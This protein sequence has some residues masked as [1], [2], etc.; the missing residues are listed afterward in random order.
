MVQVVLPYEDLSLRFV[1]GQTD[2]SRDAIAR[3]KDI[4][5]VLTLEDNLT[6]SFVDDAET[7]LRAVVCH[8]CIIHQSVG[9]CYHGLASG[10][11]DDS[12]GL[13]EGNVAA[14][15]ALWL[16]DGEIV[17]LGIASVSAVLVEGE[18]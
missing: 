3:N 13:S 15:V 18:E 10:K 4:S 6:L 1:C 14:T 5:S 7:G 11:V 9:Q 8:L 12:Y 17:E 2:I 16:F